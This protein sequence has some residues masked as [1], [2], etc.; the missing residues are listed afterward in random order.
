MSG[1]FSVGKRRP[2]VYL[3]AEE[4]DRVLVSLA[5][6]ASRGDALAVRD[7]AILAL[8]F[9]SGTRLNETRM[10]DRDDV[11]LERRRVDVRFAKRG[12]F[13]RLG[14]HAY[15]A[16]AIRAYLAGRIDGDPA[17]FLSQRRQRIA[18]R[19]IEAMIRRRVAELDLAGKHFTPH[20]ARH[21]F[22]TQLYNAPEDL[23][24][25]KDALGHE[26]IETTAIYAH[27]ENARLY[28]AID[29]M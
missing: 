11:D 15:A 2:P 10:L 21:T 26:S 23:L 28:R 5:D 8:L 25:V 14:L 19:S 12:K 22:A 3:T 7:H 29:K 9:Y 17:L 6:A 20:C 1:R 4:R 27:V 16:E 24:V 18:G 13:R